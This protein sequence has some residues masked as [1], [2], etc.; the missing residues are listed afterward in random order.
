MAELALSG[1]QLGALPIT[2]TL[3]TSFLV[4]GGILGV[5]KLATRHMKDVP[6][7]LQNIVEMAVEFVY[8]LVA[9]VESNQRKIN[10]FLPI[11][12]TFFIY[13]IL[14]NYSGLLPGVGTIGFY[15]HGHLVPLLR[16]PASDLNTTLALA[17]FSVLAA[18]VISVRETGWKSYL[19]HWFSLN[20]I[21]L[22]VGLLELV[23]EVTKVVSLSFRLF[24]NIFAGETVL[25]VMGHSFSTFLVPLPFIGLELIVGFA[26]ALVFAMLTLASLVLLTMD[27]GSEDAH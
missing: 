5:A 4:A 1:A 18:H 9:S 3:F 14:A 12:A 20:P 22:F 25:E 8:N 27:H 10:I 17:L 23:S 16:A 6:G 21:L 2:N 24:G 19:S 11:V 15:D 26:Q 13:I 7:P